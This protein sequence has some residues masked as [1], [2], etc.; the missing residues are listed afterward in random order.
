MTVTTNVQH[1]ENLCLQLFKLNLLVYSVSHNN[2]F[3]N[4]KLLIFPTVFLRNGMLMKRVSVTLNEI[5]ILIYV[6]NHQ[7]CSRRG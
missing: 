3:K 2:E 1:S 7:I 5:Y 4:R 6:L